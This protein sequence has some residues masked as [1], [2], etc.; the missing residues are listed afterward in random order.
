MSSEEKQSSG[1]IAG[2]E[3]KQSS[4]VIIRSRRLSNKGNTIVIAEQRQSPDSEAI[5]RSNRQEQRRNYTCRIRLVR[6]NGK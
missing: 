1:A 3:Q 5:A 6:Q 4:G 2:A